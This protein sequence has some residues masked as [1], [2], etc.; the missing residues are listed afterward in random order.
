MATSSGTYNFSPSNGELVLAAYERI[1]IRAPSLRQEHMQ[2]ARR[3]AIGDAQFKG[4]R[5]MAA[6][7]FTVAKREADFIRLH[8]FGLK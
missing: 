4:K 2:S 6:R 5:I 7:L 8:L 3:E 1:L